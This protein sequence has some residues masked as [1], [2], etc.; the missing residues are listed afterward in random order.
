MHSRSGSWVRRS[1]T[2][3][4]VSGPSSQDSV[5][6]QH[7]IP[8]QA[9][10][11]TTQRASSATSASSSVVETPSWGQGISRRGPS[12]GAIERRIEPRHKWN[13]TY[14]WD[15]TPQ[16]D[17][18]MLQHMTAM[19]KGWHGMLKSKH[20]KGNTFKDAV[21]SVPPSIDPSDWWTMC[22]K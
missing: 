3:D 18:E 13:M 14:R 16:T 4:D 11:P 10:V 22:E 15:W 20:Y 6:R 9:L 1:R 8:A 5:T 12:R 2:I 7:S 21:K 17:K 19:Q